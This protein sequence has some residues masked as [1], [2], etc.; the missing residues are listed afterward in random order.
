MG[1][2]SSFGRQRNF[3][4]ADRTYEENRIFE[5]KLVV[6][7]NGDSF[8]NKVSS[9]MVIGQ[10]DSVDPSKMQIESSATFSESSDSSLNQSNLE[11]YQVFFHLKKNQECRFL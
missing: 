1:Y 3:C 9:T 10:C 6:G 8:L 4:R 2:F 11:K 5:V 7:F